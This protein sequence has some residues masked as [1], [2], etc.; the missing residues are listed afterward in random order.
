MAIIRG[1]PQADD[2]VGTAAADRILAFE[3]DDLL[4]GLG[5]N[6]ELFGQAGADR[7]FG[8]AGNDTLNG[9]PGNDRLNGGAGNDILI[10]G[11]GRDQ[12]AGGA[13]ADTFRMDNLRGGVNTIFDFTLGQDVIDVSGLLADFQEGDTLAD[14]VRVLDRPA[15]TV[16]GL[17]QTGSGGPFINLVL[18]PGVENLQLSAADLG[19]PGDD[20]VGGGSGP[21]D[22]I[23][24]ISSTAAGTLQDAARSAGTVQMNKSVSDSGTIVAFESEAGNLVQNDGA[25][26]DI[27]VKNAVTGSIQL[28]SVNGAGAAANN[29]SFDPAVSGDG[30]YVAFASDA[31]NLVTGDTNNTTDVFRKD[32]VTGDVVRVSTTGVGQQAAFGPSGAF[33][34]TAISDDGTKVAFISNATN[35]VAGDTNGLADVFVKTLTTGA[36][37]RANTLAAG[38]QQTEGFPTELALSGNGNFVAFS[39]SASLLA[40]DTNGFQDVYVKNLTT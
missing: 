29:V 40:A 12:L 37:V 8:A 27:F 20:T 28:A 9:G 6:D 32:L 19:L 26:S 38:G 36:I 30:R 17:D 24:V 4:R 25:G 14:F 13:G 35:L 31:T 18:L 23:T 21:P 39:T 2:L 10:P 16:L 33:G 7:L 3:G 5:G 11:V 34:G 22:E 1:T 15:G